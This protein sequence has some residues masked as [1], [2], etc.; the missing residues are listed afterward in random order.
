MSRNPHSY[1]ALAVTLL[2]QPG[3]AAAPSARLLSLLL[4]ARGEERVQRSRALGQRGHRSSPENTPHLSPT[5][6]SPPAVE[7]A[8]PIRSL[9][10]DKRPLLPFASRRDR[11]GYFSLRQLKEILKNTHPAVTPCH[12]LLRPAENVSEPPSVQGPALRPH[13]A[14]H[15]AT[16][17]HPLPAQPTAREKAEQGPFF[18]I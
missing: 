8:S 11:N 9:G 17:P 7:K 10:Q 1:G 16:P 4:S 3:E 13:H 5:P 12:V 6:V 18:G 14:T 15:L 2:R